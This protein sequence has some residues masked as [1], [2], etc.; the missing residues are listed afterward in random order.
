MGTPIEATPGTPGTITWDALTLE[1][2]LHKA[3]QIAQLAERVA[4]DAMD[5]V[6]LWRRLMQR[7][8]DGETVVTRIP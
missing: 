1:A 7:A 8:L 4:S 2:Q 5:D 3:V 6:A